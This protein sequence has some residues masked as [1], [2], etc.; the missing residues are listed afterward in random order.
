MIAP[1]DIV[2]SGNMG[3]IAPIRTANGAL[4]YGISGTCSSEKIFEIGVL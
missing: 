1:R 3:E 4:F 2:Y